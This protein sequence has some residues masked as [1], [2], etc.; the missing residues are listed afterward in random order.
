MA[1]LLT[2]KGSAISPAERSPSRS[3]R[4]TMASRIGSESAPNTAGRAI[5][6]NGGSLYLTLA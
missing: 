2:A 1:G 6:G 5:W 4:S 3:S